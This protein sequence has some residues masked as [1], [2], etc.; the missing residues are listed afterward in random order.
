MSD[1]ISDTEFDRIEDGPYPQWINPWQGFEE[2]IS[3]VEAH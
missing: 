1:D 3:G 2:D